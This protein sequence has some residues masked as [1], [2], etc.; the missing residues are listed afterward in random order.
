MFYYDYK[1]WFAKFLGILFILHNWSFVHGTQY[2]S[3]YI[4]ILSMAAILRTTCTSEH[5]LNHSLIHRYNTC[6]NIILLSIFHYIH[7]S[8][9]LKCI[10]YIVTIHPKSKAYRRI[11][12]GV[13]LY[14]GRRITATAE[15]FVCHYDNIILYLSL[16]SR[17]TQDV[18][19]MPPSAVDYK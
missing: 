13:W 19:V 4:G 1:L 17:L 16:G 2:Y 9:D 5:E 3:I 7:F 14:L 12:T 8:I 10:R 18:S 6:D 15:Y 11:T